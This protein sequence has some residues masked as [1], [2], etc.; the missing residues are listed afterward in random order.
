MKIAVIGLRGIPSCYGGIE[1]H[2]EEI[3]SRLIKYGHKITLFVRSDY[4]NPEYTPPR[5]IKLISI[6]T[7]NS[8]HLATPIH[9]FLS[10]C[11]CLFDNYE[12][13]H[14]HAQGPCIFAWMPKLFKPHTKL[15]F[16]CHGIDWQRNKWNF[17][18]SNII[19]FGEILSA[20]LFNDHI[21]VS[22]EL[23]SYYR[24]KYNINPV[25]ITNGS[26]IEPQKTASL[27][28]NKYGLEEKSYI[29]SIG[30]LVPE[31]AIHKLIEIFRQVKTD[32][33]LVIAGG[34]A[35]TD[36]YVQYLK[37]L[38]KGDERIIFT[39]M[40]EGEMLREVY[41]NACLYLSASELEGLPLTLLE[42]M[43]YGIPALVSNIPPHIEMTGDEVFGYVF[44]SHDANIM[45]S[46]LEY[47]LSLPDYELAEMGEKGREKIRLFHNWEDVTKKH[48]LVYKLI[49]K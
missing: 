36:N 28:K 23:D 40:V 42:A 14:F 39:G 1:K 11:V 6:P 38:A 15:V 19:K 45:K 33:K 49:K 5:G 32:K 17:I 2:C 37:E 25:K 29:L 26:N 35:A 13:I 18:A 34:T 44:K 8:K 31:K 10:L 43:S 48:E 30:R 12:I 7:I 41:S 3:Y 47:I 16:T 9:S 4:I 20:K 21:T 22:D 27:I 46:K 24:K